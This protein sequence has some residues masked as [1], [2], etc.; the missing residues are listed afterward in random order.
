MF[1]VYYDSMHENVKKN[2]EK[3]GL[4]NQLVNKALQ[5]CGP[6]DLNDI[7]SETLLNYSNITM[8]AIEK[9]DIPE[10]KKV[11]IH[12]NQIM[13]CLNLKQ[14]FEFH[15][16]DK[17]FNFKLFYEEFK[18]R[19]LQEIVETVSSKMKEMCQLYGFN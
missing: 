13:D 7:Y 11:W 9:G 14:S 18:R 5:A 19:D 4:E 2:S 12:L 3:V 16:G 17:Q 10:D 8:Q 1:K 15:N 6:E